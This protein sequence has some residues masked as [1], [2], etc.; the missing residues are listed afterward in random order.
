[1]ISGLANQA[2]I[3]VTRGKVLANSPSH[4]FSVASA[5]A[6]AQ[7]MEEKASANVAMREEVCRLLKCRRFA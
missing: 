2:I 4:G 1:L 7:P 6:E 3:R 5:K